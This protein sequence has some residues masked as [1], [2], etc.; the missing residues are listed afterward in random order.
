[1]APTTEHCDQRIPSPRGVGI[2]QPT[3]V[4]V[5]TARARSFSKR[6]L[7]VAALGTIPIL[8]IVSISPWNGWTTSCARQRRNST[9]L[10]PPAGL[11]Q[12]ATDPLHFNPI[13]QLASPRDAVVNTC[14]RGHLWV[15]NELYSKPIRGVTR[16]AVASTM[17]LLPPLLEPQRVLARKAREAAAS[18][19]RT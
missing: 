12:E 16:A 1:M 8:G 10:P 2:S 14:Q 4:V 13:G 15:M 19:W 9:A 18:R 11:D 17:H 3:S 7:S 6:F 5:L